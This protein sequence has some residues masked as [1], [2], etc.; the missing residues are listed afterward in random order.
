MT[1]RISLQSLVVPLLLLIALVVGAVVNERFLTL[2]NLRNFTEQLAALGFAS[3][4]QAFVILGGGIDL[5]VGAIASLAA[6]LLAG[7]HGGNEALFVPALLLVLAGGAVVGALNGWLTVWLRVHPLIVT[8]GMAS[9]L[10]GITLLYAPQPRGSVPFWFEEF[11][12]GTLAG[13]PLSGLLLGALFLVT[14]LVLTRTPFGRRVYAIGGNAEAARL[15]GLSVKPTI[16]A[17]YALSG[18]FAALAG[19]YYVSRTGVG[20]P[21]AGDALTLASLTPVIVGGILLGGGRGSVG[22]VFLGVLLI[23]L[24]NNLLNYMNLSTFVQW[25]AQGLVI[26]AAVSFQR[27]K[28]R[29]L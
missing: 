1:A 8:L 4:G 20:D 11:A 26:I 2:G 17:T 15:T 22:G 24:L 19:A 7:I 16:I 21:H 3:L 27:Q 28:G 10:S 5:S 23:S 12:F 29:A 9:V 18:F 6:V 14:A 13:F 25:V